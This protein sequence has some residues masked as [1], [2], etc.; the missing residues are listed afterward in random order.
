HQWQEADWQKWRK[1]AEEISA[2]RE[3]AAEIWLKQ[4][5]LKVQEKVPNCSVHLEIKHGSAR[6]ELLKAATE[7]T[8]D[9]I[10][11]GAHGHQ[12]NRLFGSVPQA[13]SRHAGCSIELIRLQKRLPCELPAKE[14]KEKI[15]A[16]T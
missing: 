8:P 11:V 3:K 1:L 10:I 7:W 9:K 4:A 16:T 14:A 6:T 13:L 15:H 12:P 2:E 5:R